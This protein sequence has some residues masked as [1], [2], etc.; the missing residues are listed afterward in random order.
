MRRHKS[1]NIFPLCSLDKELADATLMEHESLMAQ[2]MGE[3]RDDKAF[4]F[5][6][7]KALSVV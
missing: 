2:R 7:R 5:E 3:Q 6:L 4:V 1:C